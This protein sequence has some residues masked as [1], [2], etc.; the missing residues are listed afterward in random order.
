MWR[1]NAQ[2]FYFTESLTGSGFGELWKR[3]LQKRFGGDVQ[4][5]IFATRFETRVSVER[6]KGGN[7]G[8]S[9][10]GFGIS[11]LFVVV[12]NFEKRRVKK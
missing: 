1:R 6:E 5:L 7:E 10:S 12:R 9:F 11:S 8:E 4:L 2:I 3:I